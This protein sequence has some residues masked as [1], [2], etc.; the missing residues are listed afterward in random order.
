MNEVKW[1]CF[2]EEMRETE[3][4]AR[5][6]DMADPDGTYEI[7]TF[8]ISEVS[9]QDKDLVSLGAIFWW[10]IRDNDGEA[11]SIIEFMKD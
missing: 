9:Q 6:Y 7:C 11:E 8:Q 3:F 5:L 2:I 10:T 1:H 4:D